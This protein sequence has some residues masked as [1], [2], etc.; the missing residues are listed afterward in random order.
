MILGYLAD[1]LGEWLQVDGVAAFTGALLAV[2]GAATLIIVSIG[3]L[4]R[5]SRVE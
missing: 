2:G 5:G 1:E 3:L 4:W